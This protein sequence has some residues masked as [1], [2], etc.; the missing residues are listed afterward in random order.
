[1]T[2]VLTAIIVLVVVI[3]LV[4]IARISAAA[5]ALGVRGDERAVGLADQPTADEVGQ[6]AKGTE[7]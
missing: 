5:L 7:R 1:M 2:A 6:P 3:V 4:Q